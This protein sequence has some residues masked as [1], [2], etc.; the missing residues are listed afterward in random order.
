MAEREGRTSAQRRRSTGSASSRSSSGRSASRSS[1]ARSSSSRS[2]SASSTRG[3]SARAQGRAAGAS[4]GTSRTRR[5]TYGSSSAS[6]RPYTRRK[7]VTREE[8]ENELLRR[9]ITI[10]LL[11]AAMVFLFLSCFGILGP[12][13]NFFRDCMFGLFGLPA[14]ILPLFVFGAALF[15]TANADEP[16]ITAKIVGATGLLVV[17]GV[18]CDLAVGDFANNPVYQPLSIYTR[19]AQGRDGG[20]ILCGSIAFFLY[21]T[22]K[23]VG[24]VMVLIVASLI[25]AVMITQRSIVDF[26]QD[27]VQEAAAISRERREEERRYREE[28]PED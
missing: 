24:T 19:C 18:I 5:S 21:S 10:I 17:L 20:G 14:Y 4:S 25:F 11:F 23:M 27:K 15:Y 12:V 7:R 9:D 3:T 16:G 26:A 8:Y 2:T 28:H 6:S 22:L 1:S 13:G